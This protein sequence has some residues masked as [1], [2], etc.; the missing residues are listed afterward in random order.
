[1]AIARNDYS[2]LGGAAR[3]FLDRAHGHF[4]A[5][6]WVYSGTTLA[7]IDPA[8]AEQVSSIAAGGAEAVDAA[9]Q[10]AYH[11]FHHPTWRAMQ[12][13]EREGLLIRL[14]A[15]IEENA[16]LLAQVESVDNG[17]PEWFA[18][19]NVGGAAGV[20]RYM[21][22]WPSKIVG[23]TVDLKMPFPGQ[24][25]A[26]TS[27]EPVGVVGAI[28]PWN[29]PLMMAVWKIAPALAAGCT[30]VLKP[31]EDSSLSALILA[32]LARQAGFPAGVLN[33]VTGAGREAGEALVQHPLVSKISFT[34]ST[35]TGKHINRLATESLKKVTLELGGK[36]PTI[37]FDDADLEVAIA[38]AANAIFTNAGQICVA[39]AR[40]YVQ[41]SVYERVVEGVA[42]HADGIVLGGGLNEGSQ[43]GPLINARQRERV[44]GYVDAA[45]DRGGELLTRRRVQGES[46]YYVAP[47]VVAGLPQGDA[48]VQEE[49]F[50]PVLAVQAFD[51]LDE[52][53][54]LAND[55]VYGLAACVFSQNINRVH[56]LLPKLKCGKVSVNHPGFPYPALPEGGTKQS[57]FGRDLGRECLDSYLDTKA[58]SMLVG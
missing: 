15:L 1:M 7:V 57:G 33:V 6:D 48:L 23:D 41:R 2:R 46:G 17:M 55:S 9:V 10:A 53:A 35:T 49:V 37:V 34:G 12:P 47:A 21:A 39:G 38:G 3:Q 24:F 20:L 25:F 11:A 4:I 45:I 44:Q 8:N 52:V 16:A 58:V 54:A 50:G 22:G 13:L 51:D 14:A 56:Q 32:D 27:R 40:L 19:I 30:V 18:G 36:S 42:R 29:V 26:Y 5:G 31:A 43:M 28:V